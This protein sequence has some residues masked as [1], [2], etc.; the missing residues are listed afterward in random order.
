MPPSGA[1]AAAATQ[2]SA[3]VRRRAV[4]GAEDLV[5]GGSVQGI[6]LT[7]TRAA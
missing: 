5:K 1:T 4:F 6:H 7:A 3:W 2:R